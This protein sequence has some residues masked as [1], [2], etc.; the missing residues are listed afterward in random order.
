MKQQLK[1]LEA[2]LPLLKASPG[3]QVWFAGM[4]EDVE[5]GRR[6]EALVQHHGLVSKV[7]I[8]GSRPDIAELL[9]A[10]SVFVMPSQQRG[11]K[12]RSPQVFLLD[13]RLLRLRSL[14]SISRRA[15]LE[16]AWFRSGMHAAFNAVVGDFL[17]SGGRFDRDMSKFSV[18]NA[19]SRYEG[20]GSDL[21]GLVHE[22]S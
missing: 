10:A 2:L 12:Y 3:L 19:A 20:I 21:C 13:F 15:S 22:Q 9:C 16:Y 7:R 17:A 4:R 8:M 11:A 5:Y 6:I 1:T 14:P 18:T